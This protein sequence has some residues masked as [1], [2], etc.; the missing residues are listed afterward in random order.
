[1]E[2]K[3]KNTSNDS[4]LTNVSELDVFKLKKSMRE[5]QLVKENN[6]IVKK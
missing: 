3:T 5:K 6:Q 1:M 4:S 2:I